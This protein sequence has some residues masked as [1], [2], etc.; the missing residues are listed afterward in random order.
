MNNN[1]ER[2]TDFGRAE[3]KLEEA[4]KRAD[5]IRDFV[6]SKDEKF[7]SHEGIIRQ[8]FQKR[9]VEEMAAVNFYSTHHGLEE[10]SLEAGAKMHGHLYFSFKSEPKNLKLWA[11]R[12]ENEFNEKMKTEYGFSISV[13]TYKGKHHKWESDEQFVQAEIWF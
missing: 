8:F 6:K 1:F 2:V 10:Y 5:E 7:S 4:Q 13:K 9:G 11:Q 12:T 3:Q